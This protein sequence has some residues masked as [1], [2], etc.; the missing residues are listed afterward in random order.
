MTD[1]N[2]NSP[3]FDQE[4]YSAS[5]DETALPG[6]PISIITATDIDTGVFGTKGII[7][8]LIGLGAEK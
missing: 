8:E 4:A 5:V 7:Y 6:D 3:I 1:A 2:D